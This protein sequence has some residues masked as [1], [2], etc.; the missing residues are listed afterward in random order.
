MLGS[1]GENGRGSAFVS[2]SKAAAEDPRYPSPRIANA[3]GRRG[4]RVCITAGQ[5]IYHHSAD[6]PDRG[7][8]AI[9]PLPPLDESIDD[10]D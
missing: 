4:Y 1:P 5:S 10:R 9:E 6:A 8:T 3:F 7:W 2:I